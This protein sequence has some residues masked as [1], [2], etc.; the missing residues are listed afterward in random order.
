MNQMLT[1]SEEEKMSSLVTSV[2]GMCDYHQVLDCTQLTLGRG[3]L[4]PSVDIQCDHHHG[5]HGNRAREA[6][7]R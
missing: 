3:F 4:H 1:K 7:L 6:Y 2:M 5:R